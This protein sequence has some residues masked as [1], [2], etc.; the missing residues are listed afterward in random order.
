MKHFKIGVAAPLSGLAGKLG[1]EM[2][3]AVKL[4]IEERN[5][6]GG[7]AGRKV[8]AVVVDDK[9]KVATAEVVARQLCD[10]ENILGIIG[11]YGSDTSLAAATIYHAHGL[12]LVA[13]IASHPMLTEAGL[14]NVFRY[15]NRDDET[16]KAMSEYLRYHL[17]KKK[18]IVVRTNTA[19]GRSMSLQ[20]KKAFT[21]LGGEIIDTTQVEEGNKDF[22]SMV[23][24]F[25]HQTDLFFYGGT[26]EGAYLLKALRA[27]GFSQLMATGDGCWDKINFMDVAGSATEKGEGVLV[28]SASSAIGD[29]RG[30]QGFAKKY[31]QRYGRVVNYAL[32]AYDAACLLLKAIEEAFA[33]RQD[34]PSP[35]D[36][37]SALRYVSFTGL[38]NPHSVTWNERGDNKAAIT[39]LNFMRTGQF[40]EVHAA[41]ATI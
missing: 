23:S 7:V 24:T 19:Y 29:V 27:A 37:I 9:S 17:H 33:R 38:A 25:S 31:E 14:P 36:V 12:P 3:Q 20:F 2:V 30:S 28:L 41:I 13:P 32:N 34:V 26:F 16:A 4:A 39:Q 21:R 11:H 35:T 5:S 1:A 40:R 6:R 8:Q 18:A 15:T 22:T 10:E